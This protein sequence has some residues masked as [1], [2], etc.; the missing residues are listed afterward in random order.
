MKKIIKLFIIRHARQ[1][2]PLCNVNVSLADEGLIQ[3]KLLGERL[4]TYN[5]DKIYSSDLIRAR[6]TAHIVSSEIFGKVSNTELGELR[7]FDYGEMTGLSDDVI[8]VRY[9]DYL[10]KRDLMNEDI[11]IPGGENGAMVY[12]RMKNSIDRILEE[13]KENDYENIVIVSHGGAIR[14]LIAGILGMPQ[15]KRF[16]FAKTMENTSITQIDY[17]TDTNKFYVEVI[18]DYAHLQGHRELLRKNFK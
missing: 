1:K 16:M 4:K 18:N 2:S 11:A 7:E 17:H 14:S 13:A 9:K 3:S 15:E 5:I 12:E 6:M 8:K 10:E